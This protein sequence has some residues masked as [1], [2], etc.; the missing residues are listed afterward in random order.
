MLLIDDKKKLPI[1]FVY[2][3]PISKRVYCFVNPNY[4]WLFFYD[5]I[6]WMYR[7]GFP[8]YSED[9]IIKRDTV[10]VLNT[11]CY[12][13]D[14]DESPRDYRVHIG[15]DKESENSILINDLKEIYRAYEERYEK[16]LLDLYKRPLRKLTQSEFAMLLKK[17]PIKIFLNSGSQSLPEVEPEEDPEE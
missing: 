4:L 13:F 14:H 11:L 7:E 16:L 8:R 10:D 9:K 6:F 1:R 17:N 3:S 15:W 5:L 2:D 12:Y